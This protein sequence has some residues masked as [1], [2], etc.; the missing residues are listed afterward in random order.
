MIYSAPGYY[1][2]LGYCLSAF[3][4]ICQNP[5]RWKTKWCGVIPAAFVTAAMCFCYF[6]DTRLPIFFLPSLL[7]VIALVFGMIYCCCRIPLCNAAYYTLRAFVLGEFSA[8]LHW[9]LYYY[10]AQFAE[11]AHHFQLKMALLVLVYGALFGVLY[12]MEHGFQKSN[13]TLW[14]DRKT[15]LQT[16][17]IALG[18]YL[19]SNISN[20]NID[21]PFSSRL[22]AEILLIRTLV[23]LGGIMMLY[24]F[25][26]HIQEI[27]MRLENE[28]LHQLM[29]R[30][31]TNYQVNK[32]SMELVQQKYHDL[33]HQI[34]YL[35][36]ELTNEEKRSCLDRMEQEIRTFE[37]HCN[38][39]NNV[40]DTILSAKIL[41]CQNL[42]IT[43]TC[44]VDGKL[45]NFIDAMDLS[46]LFGNA[47]DNAI[48]SVQRIAPGNERAIHVTV[49]Q[50]KSFAVITVG[51]S[52]TEDIRFRNGL[53]QTSKQ[54]KRYHGFGT[55][56][57][58]E[59]AHK[60]KGTATFQVENAW[61][62]LKIVL[63]LPEN[64]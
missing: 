3:M 8:S 27:T 59:T 24:A 29:E 53:P 11:E 28:M 34:S 64:N 19:F 43:M 45:L 13:E 44:V 36:E 21:T 14:I 48:E 35:R 22:P 17:L 61:F 4:Y 26:L 1:Y 60:Y 25:H 31:Y 2:A 47:L 7:V 58:L 38:T 18:V 39:G 52:C 51:N 49:Q 33:K 23:D 54:D 41:Q 15:L 62:E 5:W 6:T 42:K 10:C 57:I 55:R 20:V 12:C 32:Q 40:L 50:K 9:Q 16:F 63:P 30:Q 46:A 56:S 37:A